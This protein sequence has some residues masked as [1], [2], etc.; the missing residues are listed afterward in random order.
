MLG[1]TLAICVVGIFFLQLRGVR[2]HYFQQIGG[3]RGDKYAALES[4]VN[5]T[6]QVTRVIDVSMSKKHPGY[7]C[8]TDCELFPVSHPQHL[9]SLKQTTVNHCPAAVGFKHE[10]RAGD[11][12]SCAEKV[13][14]CHRQLTLANVHEAEQANALRVVVH[15]CVDGSN[16]TGFSRV[17]IQFQ[18]TTRALL[19]DTTGFS[20]IR[21]TEAVQMS[22]CSRRAGKKLLEPCMDS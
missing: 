16:T 14:G 19:S 17:V 13:K 9:E 6:G 8:R 2:Q 10:F 7:R 20:G 3:S 21:S 4:V 12:A 22:A 18:P 5:K 11:S 1:E 15:R